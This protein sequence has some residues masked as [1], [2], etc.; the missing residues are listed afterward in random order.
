MTRHSITVA[1][2]IGSIALFALLVIFFS[3]CTIQGYLG[4]GGHFPHLNV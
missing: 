4:L 2:E 3:Y 1:F